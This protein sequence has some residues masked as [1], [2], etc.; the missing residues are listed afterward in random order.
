MVSGVALPLTLRSFEWWGTNAMMTP[1]LICQTP[2]CLS[3]APWQSQLPEDGLERKTQASPNLGKPTL[4]IS[5]KTPYLWDLS[6]K[7]CIPEHPSP[8]S[9][10]TARWTWSVHRLIWD[11]KRCFPEAA[12]LWGGALLNRQPNKATLCAWLLSLLGHPA[13]SVSSF[14]GRLEVP[15]VS[16]SS[17]G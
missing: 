9:C 11:N 8:T 6:L 3:F 12:K 13:S 7:C 4:S 16:F 1:G 14:T 15:A 5:I 17:C 10:R 2:S